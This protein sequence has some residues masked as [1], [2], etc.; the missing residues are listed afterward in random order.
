[1]DENALPHRNF[2][3]AACRLRTPREAES[4]A[5]L[6]PL[7]RA[8]EA[9]RPRRWTP[10][11]PERDVPPVEGDTLAQP[12]KAGL[13]VLPRDLV[14][15]LNEWLK[16][17]TKRFPRLV[18][19]KRREIDTTLGRIVLIVE[20]GEHDEAVRGA[21]RGGGAEGRRRMGPRNF[22]VRVGNQHHGVGAAS[23][24]QQALR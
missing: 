14:T 13:V 23:G 12:G 7:R 9:H 2:R 1:M 18:H 11:A 3:G 6:V 24:V 19:W 4:D 17:E 15:D 10:G 16:T 5:V 20:T 22:R 21:G 8:V